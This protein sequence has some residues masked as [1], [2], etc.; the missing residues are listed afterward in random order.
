MSNPS[1]KNSLLDSRK[2][3]AAFDKLLI[4]FALYEIC[5]NAGRAPRGFTL[6]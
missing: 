1:R 5:G 6:S 3:L 4:L 2:N